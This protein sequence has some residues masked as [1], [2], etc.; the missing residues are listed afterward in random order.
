VQRGGLACACYADGVAWPSK[1]F[2]WAA[3]ASLALGQ[4]TAL[5]NILSEELERNFAVLKQKADPP[6]YFL[7]YQVTEQQLFSTSA[8]LGAL[9]TLEQQHTRLLD[10]SV[11]V[12][13]PKLDNYH[14]LPGER[15]QFTGGLPLPIEDQPAAIKQ[16]LWRETDR[17]YRQAVERLIKVRTQQQVKVAEEDQSEDFSREEPAV[18]Q[19]APVK[20]AYVADPWVQ[21]VRQWSA[22][23][24]RWPQILT[25]Q[26]AVGLQRETRYLVNT[27]GTRLQH[28]RG[29]ARIWISARAKAADGMDLVLNETFDAEDPARLPKDEEVRQAIERLARDL[30]A[31]LRAPLADPFAGPAILSGRAA[32]VFFHEIFG[33]RVEGHRQKDEAEGQTFARSLGSKVLPEFIS[34]SFDPT[35]RQFE[36]KDLNGY[37]LYDDEGVKARPVKVV[38]NGVLKTF[39][40]ARSPVRGF[41]HSNGHGRRAPGYEVVSRQSNMFVESTRTV[42]EQRLREMLIEEIRRQNKPYGLYFREVVGGLTTTARAGIQAFKVI[43]VLVYRVWPDGRPDELIRGADIVGTPLASFGRILATSDRWEVFNGYCGAESG[44]IPV[45]AV[46][47]AVLVSEIEIQKAEKSLDRPPLLPPPPEESA[48]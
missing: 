19:E 24:K 33:H 31:L 5:L 47:P 7:G 4:S 18:Y 17:T 12:G 41:T 21:R 16:R 48:P 43:P 1:V 22:E 26:V 45:A 37:Y 15:A 9:K 14:R 35:R 28:G 44:N 46:A 29:F 27:E 2:L 25:S 42:P 32:A 10:V 20:A 6:P 8:S 40:L 34:I 36:G 30:T 11:R 13:S 39:L 23:F 38:E 3:G